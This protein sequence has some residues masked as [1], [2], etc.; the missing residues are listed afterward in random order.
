MNIVIVSWSQK[1]SKMER[2]WGRDD[3]VVILKT[4]TTNE[5]MLMGESSGSLKI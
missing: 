2:L 4:W 1:T 3:Y 5:D